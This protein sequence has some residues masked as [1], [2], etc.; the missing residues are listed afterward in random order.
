MR[1]KNKELAIA[2]PLIILFGALA[3]WGLNADASLFYKSALCHESPPSEYIRNTPKLVSKNNKT[4]YAMVNRRTYRS[5]VGVCAFPDGGSPITVSHSVDFYRYSLDTNTL[6]K[7]DSYNEEELSRH[8]TIINNFKIDSFEFRYKTPD[9]IYGEI[10]SDTILEP[11]VLFT[12][13]TRNDT[14]SLIPPEKFDSY[15]S[16]QQKYKLREDHYDKKIPPEDK[17]LR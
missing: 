3:F 4:A 6:H 1:E 15:K 11:R 2:I 5:A 9:K 8:L 17:F 12:I 10:I 14:V 13:D 7:I 16:T